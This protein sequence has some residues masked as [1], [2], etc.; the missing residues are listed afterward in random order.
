MQIDFSN[1]ILVPVML[2]PERTAVKFKILPIFQWKNKKLYQRY[3][4]VYIQPKT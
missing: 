2:T 3:V 1:A 4:V